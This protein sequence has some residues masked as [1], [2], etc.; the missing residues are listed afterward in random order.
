MRAAR[1]DGRIDK[2]WPYE[3]TKFSD[4]RTSWETERALS[5]DVSEKID[6]LDYDRSSTRGGSPSF[7]YLVRIVGKSLVRK[8]FVLKRY[9]ETR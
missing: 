2:G 5:S 3:K 7:E 8:S 9:G 1:F 6:G 4:E